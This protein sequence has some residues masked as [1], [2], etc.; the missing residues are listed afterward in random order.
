MKKIALLFVCWSCIM[1]KAQE[2]TINYFNKYGR[3]A[4]DSAS[5]TFIREFSVRDSSNF[6]GLR[7]FYKNGKIK[8]IGNVYFNN[9]RMYRQDDFMFF[10]KIGKKTKVVKYHQNI[11]IGTAFH[12]YN[13]GVLMKKVEYQHKEMYYAPDI[14]WAQGNG[15]PNIIRD[16]ISKTIYYADTAGKATVTDGN[17][18]AVETLTYFDEDFIEEGS[19]TDGLREGK[20][21]GRNIEGTKVF[22]ESYQKG[23]L[24]KGIMK[25]NQKKYRY[26]DLFNRPIFGLGNNHILEAYLEKIKFHSTYAKVDSKRPTKY[27]DVWI[28]ITETGKV[29]D[30][31]VG[32]GL[33]DDI[34]QSLYNAVLN[35][36]KWK[37]GKLRGLKVKSTYPLSATLYTK[38]DNEVAELKNQTQ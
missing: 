1:A 16:V 28:T 19:Y 3:P 17:G 31:Y 18:Y 11:P 20:W 27:I 37:V 9:G 35:M 7:E 6:I 32:E 10:N 34:K 21:K 2:I 15:I 38:E 30:V 23:K 8:S 5:V 36:P 12:F 22:E 13:N 24:V 25:F 29:E 4:Q 26:I 33:S 14:W